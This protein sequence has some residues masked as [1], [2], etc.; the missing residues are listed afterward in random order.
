MLKRQFLSLLVLL[1][2]PLAA[3][4]QGGGE[5]FVEGT[6]YEVIAT[7]IRT[8]DPSKIEVTEFFWYGCGHCYNFEPM[9]TQWKKTLAD[10]VA[11]VGSPAAWNKAMELHARAYY[12][13][14]VMGVMDTM[15]MAIF[16]AMNVDRQRLG[17]EDE[18]AALFAANGADEAEFRKAFNSFGVTSQARQ[19]NA[20]AR[21][22]KIT[23][24]PELMVNGKYR[25]DTRKAGSQANMLKIADYLIAKERAAL[26]S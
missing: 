18:I 21:S 16:Q 19:A 1:A 13:A 11:F 24:T 7:P 23:G 14:Q 8:A 17:S 2:L 5:E 10:D 4:A 22:A 15:H 20:R 26:G 12:S 9:I 3:C 25:I 6:H